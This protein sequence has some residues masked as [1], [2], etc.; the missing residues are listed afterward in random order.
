MID[1]Q[2]IIN[3]AWDE[4]M[5]EMYAK[6]QPSADFHQI[7]EDVKSGKIKDDPHDP[8]YNRYYLSYDEFQYILHKYIDAYGLNFKKIKELLKTLSGFREAKKII[9]K[10][11]PDVVIRNRWLYLWCG[12]NRSQ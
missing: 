9:A 10:F 6:A 7:L 4:C 1:R 8:V 11:K 12:Y 5:T 3:R 2:F